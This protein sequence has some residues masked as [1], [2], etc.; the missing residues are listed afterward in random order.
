MCLTFQSFVADTK[1]R[2]R[3]FF[4]RRNLASLGTLVAGI[5]LSGVIFVTLRDMETRNA[6]AAFNGVAQERLDALE[7]NIQ[8]TVNNLV[9][10]GSLI[11][12]KPDIDRQEFVRFTETLLARNEAI[13]ALEWIP[14]VP[15]RSRQKYEEDRRR[16]GFPSFQFTERSS[17]GQMTRAGSRDE[18]FPVLFV[19]PFQGNEKAL[20]FDLSSDPVRRAALDRSA[21]T[22]TLVAT[23]RLALVQEI[24]D[25]YG[26]LVYRPVYEGGVAPATVQGRRQ[27]LAG[28]AVAVF[29]VAD[30]VEKAGV[31]RNSATDLDLAIFDRDAK[32][33]ERLLYPKGAPHDGVGDL[34]R[35]LGATRTI[36]VAGRRW[37][38]AV[39]PGSGASFQPRHWSSWAT[40]L[41]GLLLT[42]LLTGHLAERK[43]AEET[44]RASEERFRSLICNMPDVIWTADEKGNFAYISPNIERLSGFATEQINSL[45]VRLYLACVH[46]DDLDSVKQGLHDLYA[47]G[48]P[49]DVE[50]RVRRRDGE[51]IWVRNRALSSYERNGTVYA[52]GI[53]SD[54]TGR[55]RIE[56]SLTVQS[57]TAHALAE[58]SSLEEAAP[59]ILQALCNMLGW[60]SGVLWGV[61]RRNNILRWIE[62]WQDDPVLLMGLEESQKKLTFAYGE[63][64][65]G[66]VWKNG[67]PVW[68]SDITAIDGPMRIAADWGMRSAVT[69]PISSGGVV[70]SVMQL[71]SREFEQRDEQV[72]QMLVAIAGQIGP[73]LDRRRTEEALHQSEERARLLFATIPHPAFVFDRTTLEF[74]EINQA[75]V[76]QYGYSRDEFLRMK[77]TEIRPLED[78]PKVVQRLQQLKS[79]KGGA[80]QWRHRA[81]DGRIIDAE[82]YFHHLEYDG[83][84]A[85]LT[86]AQD[87]T[88][89]NRLEI[90]L[91]QAQK[92]ESVGGLAAGI[93]HE[94]NTPI[95]FVGDNVR[96]LRD[97]FG[98]LSKILYKYRA[99][100]ERVAVGERDLVEEIANTEKKADIDYLVEEIPKSLG[101]ALDGVARV[102]TLV[103]A[104]KVFAHP[105][106]AEKVA[107]NINDALLSTLTVARNELKYVANVETEFGDV[108]LVVCNVGELNQVFL[109]L[110]VNAAHAIGEV[111]K[112]SDQKGVIRVRTAR[113][114]GHVLISISDTGCGIP[115]KIRDKVFDPFFT[116]KKIGKGTGQGLAIARSAIVERHGGTLTFTSEVGKGTTFSIRLPVDRQGP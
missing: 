90:E 81:K 18:Y 62:S 37:E 83:R 55:K 76:Q 95:Q 35:G 19:S 42:S 106:G 84:K 82:I 29:R 17:A 38:L 45:G 43:R 112:D 59:A 107:T 54:I 110:L 8:L 58:C 63:G 47:E 56:E 3:S 6:Q 32:P 60:D 108:P 48:K 93:A 66:E 10:L 12:V 5:I 41:A 99:L 116:T 61:D 87:V 114:N 21:D 92:L 44:L 4:V 52:D 65:A 97:A 24:S 26:F 103:Q 86:I 80:G 14:R 39:Y 77:L 40:L 28:F 75:A 109:N 85:C 94:I 98:D 101:Q 31:A 36:S 111:N 69:F 113:D 78:A 68:I 64:V 72:M 15:E 100:R 104:M 25:Q 89:R 20:G 46:P 102:A 16:D 34:P 50:C 23:S 88:E 71:F 9:S 30:I 91:R 67:A 11:E 1:G 7:T 51:W 27:A 57:K 70:L 96:F 13:Q 53:I 79:Y 74:L 2:D 115:E 33:G 22:G 105:D 73:L 49:Y